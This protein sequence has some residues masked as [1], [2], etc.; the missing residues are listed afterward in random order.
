MIALVCRFSL[1]CYISGQA[2]WL[3]RRRCL[4][5][6]VEVQVLADRHE[7][8]QRPVAFGFGLPVKAVGQQPVSQPLPTTAT[9]RE[10][11]TDAD[12]GVVAAAALPDRR[13]QGERDSVGEALDQ[14][15][16]GDGARRFPKEGV[17]VGV[18]ARCVLA[19]LSL[20]PEKFTRIMSP[21]VRRC[22]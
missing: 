1:I 8:R 19:R 6:I 3:K 18:E 5:N 7:H 16:E 10:P 21:L 2:I 14:A 15:V 20:R 12:E 4:A 9:A 11:G 13:L 22:V 17:D